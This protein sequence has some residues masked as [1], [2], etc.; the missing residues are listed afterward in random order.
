[1]Q[2]VLVLNTKAKRETGRE[3]QLNNI[4]AAKTVSEVI[5]T[6]LGPKSMLKMVLDPMGGIAITNDGNAILRE[7]DVQHPTAKSMIELSRAQDESVGDGTTS[8]IILAGEFL[9][10]SQ[11]WIE[12]SIHPTIIISAYMKA[13]DDALEHLKSISKPIDPNDEETI[14]SVI[15]SCINTKFI[16]TWSDKMCKLALD[17]VNIVKVE[18]TGYKEIDLKQYARIEKIP[19]GD[20]TDSCVIPGCVINKD[21][22]HSK[23]KRRIENPRVILLDCPLEY[24]KGES[25]TD[26]ECLGSD[27]FARLLKIEEEQIEAMCND[28]IRL[29]PDLVITEKG[30]SDLAEHFFVKAG[31][32]ALRRTKKSDNNRLA[33]VTGA[34]ICHRTDELQESDVGTGASLFEVQKIGDEYFTFITGKS[35]KACTILLRGANKDTLNEVERNLHDAMCVARNIAQQPCLVPGGGASEISI[36][37][38]LTEKMKSISGLQQLPYGSIAQAL[39]VIPRTLLQNCGGEVVRRLTEL[40]AKHAQNPKENATWGIDGL[41]GAIA[42]MNETKIWEPYEVKAQTLKTAI[43]AACMVLRVDDVLS[44]LSHNG[45]PE[46]QQAAEQPQEMFE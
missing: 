46:E 37:H 30:L 35:P 1:M 18:Q 32:T 14:L 22:T 20:I 7:I 16:G 36:A 2:P 3:A 42:D 24:K 13:L 21:V 5:R 23:M 12:R 17:A 45:R 9:Q 8:V 40:K 38:A 44:G 31:I 10:V 39:E 34:T 26:V 15:K 29:K 43:E 4:S 33:R 6:C 41:T 25:M 11:Q 27:D 19:G 28:I